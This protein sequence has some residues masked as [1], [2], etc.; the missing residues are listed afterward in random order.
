MA[1]HELALHVGSLNVVKSFGTWHARSN[2]FDRATTTGM[3][4]FCVYE[5]VSFCTKCKP[6]ILTFFFY[7]KYEF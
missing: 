6:L 2:S 4:S 5:G 3:R 1:F 7:V